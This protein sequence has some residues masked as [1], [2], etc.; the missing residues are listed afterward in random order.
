MAPSVRRDLDPIGI[1]VRRNRFRWG[2]LRMALPF[3]ISLPTLNGDFSSAIGSS[4][5]GCD[6]DGPAPAAEECS[7]NSPE[8][9]G[10]ARRM[11]R[12]GRHIAP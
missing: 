11:L 7:P 3:G 5:Q 9:H 10:L 12:Q 8:S 4:P 6:S 2:R 1:P